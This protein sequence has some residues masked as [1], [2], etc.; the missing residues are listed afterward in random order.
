MRCVKAQT[1]VKVKR[2]I[3]NESTAEMLDVILE[4]GEFS[5]AQLRTLVRRI[6]V[7]RNEDKSLDI[8]LEF[9]GDF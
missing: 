7:Y 6:V 2:L 9:N 3:Q 1:T 5:D 4:K 8:R